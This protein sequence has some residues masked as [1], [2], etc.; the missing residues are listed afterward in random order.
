LP[1]GGGGE[2]VDAGSEH[3]SA[4]TVLLRPLSAALALLAQARPQALGLGVGAFAQ[5]VGVV[6]PLRS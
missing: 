6:Y 5:L 2:F 1:R 4:L 3:G